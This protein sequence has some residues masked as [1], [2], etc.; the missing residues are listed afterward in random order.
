MNKEA[1]ISAINS[2]FEELKTALEGD[3]LETIRELTLD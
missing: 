3:N 1:T 2:K